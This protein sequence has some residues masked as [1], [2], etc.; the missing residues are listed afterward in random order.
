MAGGTGSLTSFVAAAQAS[1]SVLLV[2]SYGALSARL[3]LLDGTSAKAISKI[4]VRLFLPALLFVKIGSEL[5]TG[6][7]SRYVVVL[8]WAFVAHLISFLIGVIAHLIFG[9]PD[10]ITAAIMFNN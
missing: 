8:I 6:S 1:L 5:H 4:C 10:W 3:K 7:A 9:M 2:F